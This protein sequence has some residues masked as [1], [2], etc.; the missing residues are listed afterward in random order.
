MLKQIQQDNVDWTLVFVI[1]KLIRDLGLENLGFRV[2]T[3]AGLL[4]D[5]RRFK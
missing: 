1:P 4:L 3:W 5:D 2:P